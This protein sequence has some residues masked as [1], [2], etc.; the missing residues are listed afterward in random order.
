M[1]NA[2]TLGWKDL[3]SKH[4]FINDKLLRLG[5]ICSITSLSL[6]FLLYDIRVLTV[7]C[8]SLNLSTHAQSLRHVWLFVTPWTVAHRAPLSMGFSQASI[9]IWVGI[10]FSRICF[11]PG[12]QPAA[13]G[14]K[15][16]YHWV[17]LEALTEFNS[18]LFNVTAFHWASTPSRLFA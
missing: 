6:S 8:S 17:S 3:G 5:L 15:M 11:W 13:P 9:L 18:V 10:S 2:Q 16:L 7:L 14:R 1:K 4:S 12:I